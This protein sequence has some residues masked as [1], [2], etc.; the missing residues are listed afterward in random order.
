MMLERDLLLMDVDRS[1]RRVRFLFAPL[2]FVTAPG[3]L[4][5][6]PI[7]HHSR[8]RSCDSETRR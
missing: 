2:R 1:F 6:P 8:R 3:L 7:P 4:D 5:D